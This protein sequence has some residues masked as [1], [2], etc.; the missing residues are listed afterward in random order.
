MRVIYLLGVLWT[1]VALG[2]RAVLVVVVGR[3]CRGCSRSIVDE[4]AG[5]LAA[6]QQ[7]GGKMSRSEES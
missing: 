1:A 7:L 2:R 3:H 6:V 5:C 4:N